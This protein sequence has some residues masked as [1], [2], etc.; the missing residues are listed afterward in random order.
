MKT[1]KVA[2]V[3]CGTIGTGVARILLENNPKICQHAGKRLELACIVDKDTETPRSAKLPKG[4]ITDDLTRVT[5]DSEI[6]A[7]VQLIGGLEP[8]RT[9]MLK[10]L[11]SG[12]DVITANKALLAEHGPELFDRARSLGRSIAFEA[13][14]GGGIPIISTIGQSLTANRI[15]S[16]HAILNGTSNFILS[17][18]EQNGSDYL[19]S[20]REAQRLGFAEAD[21]SMDVDGSDAAQK[22]AI[23]AHLAFGARVDWKDIPR[24]GIDSLEVADLD[25]AKAL[26]Y[27]VKLL[28]TADL[29]PEGLEL[30]VG[31]TL[32][33]TGTPMAE[34]HDAYNAVRVIG[35]TVG[36]VFLHG[37]GAGQ[38][39][40]A[41][42]V[43]ADLID[44]VLGRTR[45]TFKTLD[46]WSDVVEAPVAIKDP[47]KMKSRFYLRFAVDDCPGVMSSVT[48]ILGD[49][50]IS[51][52]SV[53]QHEIPGNGRQVLPLVIMTHTNTEGAVVE[54]LE[55]IRTLK[56]C[57]PKIVTMR[58]RE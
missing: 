23:L 22:L 32:V 46:L 56:C 2:I 13:A 40:T 17:Q 10:L 5:D 31:P 41:S 42:A 4:L 3:G 27:S 6:T 1:A 19:S 57:Q 35:N 8:A 53:V 15:Q 50:G 28:A 26:G 12:K 16:I 7:V 43:C 55:E 29:T 25:N 48:G 44:T 34:V 33:K 14:V 18:M 51:I 21:P 36:R 52:S 37:L 11:E 38:N 47:Q 24:I 20:V 30:H 58:I 49:H 45:I 54:A 39:P 9:I